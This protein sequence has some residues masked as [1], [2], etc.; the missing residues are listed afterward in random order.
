MMLPR[1][2]VIIVLV[3]L[4]I[5]LL[6]VNINLIVSSVYLDDFTGQLYALLVLTA[7]AAE[8]AIGLAICI[9]YYRLRGGISLDYVNLLKG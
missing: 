6:A 5:M 8:I 3:S 1:R 4:E 9:A 2:H 7:A